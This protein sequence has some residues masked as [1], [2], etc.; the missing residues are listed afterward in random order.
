MKVGILGTLCAALLMVGFPLAMQAG[1][2][3]DT[4][5]DGIVDVN[6]NCVTVPNAAPIDC[7]TDGDGI[8]NWCDCDFDQ[9][10]SCNSLDFTNPSIP[11]NPQFLSAFLSGTPSA[12]G[13]EDMDCNGSVNSLDFT[14]PSQQG[15]W[16]GFLNGFTAGAPGSAYPGP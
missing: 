13:A 6:D 11:S 8:G 3:P 7:D 2:A 12:N 10:G 14:N 1:V 16:G 9:N 4:D 5:G 15:G